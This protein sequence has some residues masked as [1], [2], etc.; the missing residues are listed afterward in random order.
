[1]NYISHNS[2]HRRHLGWWVVV[3]WGPVLK[4]VQAGSAQP[5]PGP[6]PREAPDPAEK[7]VR[8]PGQLLPTFSTSP[9]LGSQSTC[10]VCA[11][12]PTWL[13]LA[14]GRRTQMSGIPKSPR[15]TLNPAHSAHFPPFPNGPL[16]LLE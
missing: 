15:R 7:G 4:A 10:L 1:M 12:K 8:G 5:R 9:P 11:E 3:A 13:P 14:K 6:P 16:F 2:V